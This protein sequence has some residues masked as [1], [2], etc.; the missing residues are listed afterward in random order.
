MY[1]TPQR[2]ARMT[3]QTIPTPPSVGKMSGRIISTWRDEKEDE[4]RRRKWAFR[5]WKR[6]LFPKAKIPI[7]FLPP[8]SDNSCLGWRGLG[9]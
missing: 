3:P 8:L 9:Q 2:D 1:I 4:L 6:I 7:I 5:R